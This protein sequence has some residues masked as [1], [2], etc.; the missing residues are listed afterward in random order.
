[1]KLSTAMLF[2]SILNLFLTGLILFAG[3][4]ADA[5]WGQAVF[6]GLLASTFCA[7]MS[8]VV[9]AKGH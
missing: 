7:V 3:N 4:P 5:G 9:D 1:M 2:G 8:A 6:A